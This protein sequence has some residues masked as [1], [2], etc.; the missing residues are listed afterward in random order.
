MTSVL[1]SPAATPVILVVDD[2][3]ANRELLEGYLTDLGYEVRQAGD[4]QEALQAID[5]EEPDLVLLDIQ[6]PRLDGLSVC[7]AIK[8]HSRLRL[9]PVVLITALGDRATMLAGLE[10][11]ADDFL[12]K[13]FD[14]QELL[15]RTKVLL[16]ER[17]LN[18]KLDATE[19]VLVAFARAVEAR[20]LYTIHHADRVGRMARE[21]A[22]S[23]GVVPQ[24]LA[25]IYQ[26]A[27]LHDLGKIAVPD[28]VL[29]KEGP[30]SDD[31]WA[32]M[33]THS[34]VGERICAP[35]RSTSDFLPLIRHHHERV[36]GAGYPDHLVGAAIPFGARIVA[37]ADAFDAMLSDRPYRPG[38]GREESLRRLRAGA[39]TQWDAAL[40]EIFTGLVDSRLFDDLVAEASPVGADR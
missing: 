2:V 7:R 13:P 28:M 5:A 34:E 27:I 19:T 12:P 33:R 1:A 15:I 30:L 39:G 32:L 24:D 38:L 18:K 10:A 17:L 21:I 37:I 9:V 16:K 40:V 35:L 22:R 25:F 3:P 20:D 11:G 6:M 14:A 8:Q 31:E 26:G 36:D 29:K 4:G 23:A